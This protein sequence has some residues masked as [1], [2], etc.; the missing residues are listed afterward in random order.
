MVGA[1]DE[2]ESFLKC[3]LLPLLGIPKN[4]VELEPVS[5]VKRVTAFN[6]FR[7]D[8]YVY[9]LVDRIP[10][11][12]AKVSITEDNLKLARNIVTAFSKVSRYKLLEKGT[13]IQHEYLSETLMKKS[14]EYAIQYGICAWITGKTSNPAVDRLMSSLERWSV[15]TYEGRKV[16]FGFVINSKVK[17]E[18]DWLEFLEDDYSATLTDCIHSVIELDAD[19]KLIAYHSLTLDGGSRHSEA[20]D[21][22]PY[23]FSDV[24]ANFISKDK[25]GIFLL[26][27]GDIIISK[28][29][30]IK[31]VK[32]N[33][34]WLN[35]SFDAFKNAVGENMVLGDLVPEIYA[36]MLDVSFSHT[37][38][39]IAVVNNIEQ[40]RHEGI[41]SPSDDVLYSGDI[42]EALQS[43]VSE[44]DLH[45]RLL[46]RSSILA[47]IGQN[48]FSS[49][50]RKL[51]AELIAMDGAFI[52]GRQGEIFAVGAIIQN[53]S[54][55][56]GGG[57]GAACKRLSQF[58]M[59]IKISTDGYI[60]MFKG[61]KQVYS[62]K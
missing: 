25:V 29:K 44:E 46:K 21:I 20:H 55:S 53:E 1:V 56:S 8:G 10:Y 40:L 19:A 22:M 41:L 17:G 39:I 11:F 43:S 9:F 42:R 38:G 30:Q 59:A 6:V 35:M 45:K 37:G 23:R 54:G 18:T 26:N 12:R 57:R 47:L 52:I 48:T 31:F 36:S 2:Y 34:K 61:G 7:Q 4:T 60:E 58:G 28:A 33:L 62:V 16:T 5:T 15:Q 24:L 50:D 27:N 49:L 13:D 3:Y 32:R 14:Y 51:K